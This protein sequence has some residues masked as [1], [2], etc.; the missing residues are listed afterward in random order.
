MTE[1]KFWQIIAASQPTIIKYSRAGRRQQLRRLRDVLAALPLDQII[2][3]DRLFE[4]KLAAS[5]MWNL[6]AI[7]YLIMGGCSDDGFE[8]FRRWLISEGQDRFELAV[9]DPET[10][11]EGIVGWSDEVLDFE[12]FGYVAR[13]V[14]KK[15]TRKEIPLHDLPRQ[16]EP[17]GERDDW[18]DDEELRR[19]FPR[20]MLLF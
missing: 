16:E 6:W 10:F 11:G 4:E 2:A 8:Y 19:R 17:S 1:E 14:Y 12:E 13:D 15:K 7:A 5:Y 3:F 20:L 9:N 18:E